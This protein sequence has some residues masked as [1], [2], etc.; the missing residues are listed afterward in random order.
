M[1]PTLHAFLNM[2]VRMVVEIKRGTYASDD[3]AIRQVAFPSPRS[4]SNMISKTCPKR[5]RRWPLWKYQK[6]PWEIHCFP[7][8]N[9]RCF[10]QLHWIKLENGVQPQRVSS[11]RIFGA[12]EGWIPSSGRISG[13]RIKPVVIT[14]Y[15]PSFS[16]GISILVRWCIINSNPHTTPSF[17]QDWISHSHPFRRWIAINQQLRFFVLQGGWPTS[18]HIA[19][20]KRTS[21]RIIP[22]IATG[23]SP[24]F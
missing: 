9:H 6:N 21:E 12:V 5:G 13:I 7:C 17:F 16:D 22:R 18:V 14:S 20:L 8:W 3:P 19:D 11:C 2:Y 10:S 1:G 4:S 24:G 15:S 23:K